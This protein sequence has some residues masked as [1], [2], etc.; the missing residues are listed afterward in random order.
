MEFLLSLLCR[1]GSRQ[2]QPETP[3]VSE[4]AREQQCLYSLVPSCSS[5]WAMGVPRTCS[6]LGTC[7]P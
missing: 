3:G 2:E 5:Y 4:A 6:P 7:C 1:D